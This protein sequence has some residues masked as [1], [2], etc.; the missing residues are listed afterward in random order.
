MEIQIEVFSKLPTSDTQQRMIE[1]LF[2]MVAR[3]PNGKAAEGNKNKILKKFS[4]KKSIHWSLNL[5]MKQR[6]FLKVFFSE[7]F[8]RH[9][10]GEVNKTR[11]LERKQ[12]SLTNQAPTPEERLI[13]HEIFMSKDTS[14]FIPMDT[15]HHE[16]MI[17]AQPTVK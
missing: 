16:T 3:G 6:D 10:G 5:K 1:A 4:K 12:M 13:I 7:V 9:F 17:L 8:L 14:N 2:S 11:R 15:T